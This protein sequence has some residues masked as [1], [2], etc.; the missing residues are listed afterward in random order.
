MLD[1][2]GLPV[3]PVEICCFDDE[4][5]LAV[6][7]F[8]RRFAADGRWILRLP[9]EDFCQATGQPPHKKYE[10]DGGPRMAD[11]LTVLAASENSEADRRTFVCAQLA[12]WLLAA[13]DGH[14]K[15]FSIFLLAGTA[16][17]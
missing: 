11:C 1:G 10:A 2:V 6:E 13:T 12:F 16:T 15:N 9:Q 8:D 17:A 3:A 4:K 14:A 7:R 5:A